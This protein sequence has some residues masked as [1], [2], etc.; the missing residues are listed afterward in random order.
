MPSFESHGVRGG[1]WTG[2]LDAPARPGRVC[3]VARG[4]PV[5]G[6]VLTD[7][8]GG[9]WTLRVDLPAALISEGVT[10][11]TLIADDAADPDAPVGP[12]AQRL[13]RLTLAAGR[14]LDEDLAAEVAQIRAELDLLKREF[15]RLATAG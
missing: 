1:V 13:A 14:V 6:A 2:W 15:R 11:L 7:G 5:A 12:D 9:G 10:S 8:A 3:L 4:E